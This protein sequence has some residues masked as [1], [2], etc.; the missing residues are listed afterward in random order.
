MSAPGGNT[1][2]RRRAGLARDI[3]VE[4]A[5]ARDLLA[6][7]AD[8]VAGD[9][10]LA[11]TAV[12]GETDFLEA[13]GAAVERIG[14]IEGLVEGIGA[15]AARLAERKARLSRQSERLRSA[16]ARG[17]EVAG[18]DRAETPCGTVSRRR[19]PRKILENDR[20]R[21]PPRFWVRPP[22]PALE[23]DRAALKRALEAG[24]DIPGAMLDNG[25]F[26]LAISRR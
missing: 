5:A 4:A 8:A 20:S 15:A 14:E 18:I 26:S 3:E 2:G 17:L 7:L 22:E 1:A 25:G 16:L 21:I 24:E 6:A 11:A 12:E 23:I 19:T 13:A 9:E 10:D